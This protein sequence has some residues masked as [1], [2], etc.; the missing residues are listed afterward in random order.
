MKL[1]WPGVESTTGGSPVP[2]LDLLRSVYSHPIPVSDRLAH[3]VFM[4]NCSTAETAQTTPN[5][6]PGWGTEKGPIAV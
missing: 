1:E 5:P 6:Q 2:R 4:F 3:L